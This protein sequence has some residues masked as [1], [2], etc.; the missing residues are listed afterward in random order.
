MPPENDLE[1]EEWPEEAEYK[2]GSKH[3]KLKI[4]L[5]VLALLIA[6]LVAFFK[7]FYVENVIIEG[8]VR[9]SDE[10]IKELC[11]GPLSVNSVLFS[12]FESR[13][14]LSDIAFLD[15]VTVEYVSPDTVRLTVVE[16]QLV[17]YFEINGY[18]YYFDQKGM[19][20]EVLTEPDEAE[21]KYVPLIRGVGADN[22]GLWHTIEFESPSVLN[23]IT[24]IRH[25]ID[26]YDIL[27]DLVFF[28]ANLDIYLY[29]GNI[30]V[31]IGQDDLLE[32]KMARVAA[33]LPGLE[34]KTGTLHLENY[35][36][37]TQNIVFSEGV[38]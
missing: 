25:M 17:G 26:K 10:E 6:G 16:T 30:T 35:T 38:R 31:Y 19:V 1:N 14:D 5:V 20:T 32:E 36:S 33:I 23:T 13:I 2:K 7:V 28:E 29:Y 9:Y 18:Y 8:N 15:H 34:G 24:A 12:T 4:V 37:D 21:G 3:L 22:I 27:P 11:L